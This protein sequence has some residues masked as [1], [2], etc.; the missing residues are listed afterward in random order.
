MTVRD[1]SIWVLMSGGVD[2]SA[3]AAFYSLEYPGSVAGLFVDYGQASASREATAVRAVGRHLHISV[4]E[5]AWR[6]GRQFGQGEVRG[7]NAFLVLGALMTVPEAASLIALGIHAGTNY[8]DCGPHFVDA[9]QI[10]ADLYTGGRV[11]VAAPFLRWTKRDIWTFCLQRHIPL[12]LT[13]SCERGADQ[14]CGECLSCR[15]LG[16]LHACSSRLD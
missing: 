9:V 5:V 4:M 15:D 7:R 11:Q 16:A 8:P 1:P 2:S 13:Y 12:A 6:G 10:V 14:P 3:C